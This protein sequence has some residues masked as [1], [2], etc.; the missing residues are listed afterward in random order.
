[1]G[2]GGSG[3]ASNSKLTEHKPDPVKGSGTQ[4]SSKYEEKEDSSPVHRGPY[5][6]GQVVPL[7]TVHSESRMNVGPDDTPKKKPPPMKSAVSHA[8]FEVE[9]KLERKKSSKWNMVRAVVNDPATMAIISSQNAK[10]SEDELAELK[11][12]PPVIKGSMSRQLSSL[13]GTKVDKPMLRGLS[14]RNFE[15]KKSFEKQPSVEIAASKSSIATVVKKS[16]NNKKRAKVA[17]LTDGSE[18]Y[19]SEDD[20]KVYDEFYLLKSRALFKRNRSCPNFTDHIFK[21]KKIV[22][23]RR[24]MSFPI[25]DV[26]NWKEEQESQCYL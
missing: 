26:D 4:S 16:M 11:A 14:M 3:G 8:K 1:M 5:S 23:R 2:G 7:E 21:K 20:R 19:D 10:L 25:H 9:R 17:F 12:P 6:H 24:R 15:K 13:G 18:W 22:K